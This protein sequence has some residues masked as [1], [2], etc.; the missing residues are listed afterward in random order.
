MSVI[1]LKHLFLMCITPIASMAIPLLLPYGIIVLPENAP[2]LTIISVIVLTL[3]ILNH[4]LLQDIITQMNLESTVLHQ[5]NQLVYQAE[6]YSQLSNAYKETRRVI[7]EVKRYNSFITSCVQKKEYDRIVD[8][9]NESN[10]ELEE[11]FVKIN[12]GN[13]VIDTFITNYNTIASEKGIQFESIIK[14]DK[15][16]IPVNDYDLCIILGNLLDNSFNESDSFFNIAKSYNEFHIL[17]KIL[18]TDSFF[19]IHVSN[20]LSK[21]AKKEQTNNNLDHGFGIMNIKS[22]VQKYDGLYYQNTTED[23]YETTISIPIIFTNTSSKGCT[24]PRIS[25]PRLWKTMKIKGIDRITR[26]SD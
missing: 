21:T 11:R 7:H 26:N 20:I 18:T 24:N 15:D 16:M 8:F 13:L 22:I 3:N 25:T 4:F 10:K 19:V 12:T 6:K 1:S 5:K 14:I 23:S 17:A 9:I 2:K